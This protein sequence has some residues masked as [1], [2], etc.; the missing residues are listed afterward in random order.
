MEKQPFLLLIKV[1]I[2]Q[3]IAESEI[4]KKT[5]N[6]FANFYEDTVA[7]YGLLKIK[8]LKNFIDQKLV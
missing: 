3:Y 4:I 8:A 1:L 2:L 6:L 7:K 5:L